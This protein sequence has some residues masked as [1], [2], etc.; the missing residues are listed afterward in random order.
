MSPGSDE[1]IL[2]RMNCDNCGAAMDLI[3]SGRYFRCRYCGS[4]HFPEPVDAEGIRITGAVGNATPCPV[5]RVAMEQALL[6]DEFPVAFCA[7]CRGV[8]MPRT[9]FAMVV[10]KRRA[11]AT[12]P[13]VVPAPL[14]RH[15][16]ERELA[17][18][19]CGKRLMTDPYAGP[20]NVVIDSCGA[21]DVIWLD[22]GEMRQIVD[23]PGRD[24]GSRE[25]VPI[26]DY[27]RGGP[28]EKEDQESPTDPFRALFDFFF[29]R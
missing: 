3:E 20:G 10:N 5:C 12:A 13:P 4:F 22:F 18:S 2:S 29:T 21:C 9:T 17:C 7:T 24:R 23:A 25:L 6:D 14:D 27:V 15:A 8:L 16:L 1:G 26:D 11:W 28:A 19:L